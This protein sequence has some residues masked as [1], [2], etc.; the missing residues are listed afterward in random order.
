MLPHLVSTLSIFREVFFRFPSSLVLSTHFQSTFAPRIRKPQQF[1]ARC[2]STSALYI[3]S[4]VVLPQPLIPSV[5]CLRPSVTSLS[6]LLSTSYSADGG[7]SAVWSR[8][9]VTWSSLR[10]GNGPC[11]RHRASPPPPSS[12]IPRRALS[13]AVLIESSMMLSRTSLCI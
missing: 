10:P 3:L 8:G 1:F 9:L 12:P 4:S 13:D 5:H 11:I 7:I 2:P 6:G